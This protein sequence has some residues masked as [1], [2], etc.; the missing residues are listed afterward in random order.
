MGCSTICF[1]KILRTLWMGAW[2]GG[3]CR[4]GWPRRRCEY[5]GGTTRPPLS[6]R[7]LMKPEKHTLEGNMMI[8]L[9]LLLALCRRSLRIRAT[10]ISD[11]L[12]F[13]TPIN[14][15]HLINLFSSLYSIL[16]KSRE[17]VLCMT[18][19]HAWTRFW[20]TVSVIM[21]LRFQKLNDYINCS[22]FYFKDFRFCISC[23][24][25]CGNIYI[26]E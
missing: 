17:I 5:P 4:G 24:M 12:S 18:K 20:T 23:V 11:S 8:L 15:V 26:I 14:I 22:L 9:L 21:I 13:R 7:V 19:I 6:R 2:I 1:R 16:K 3:V 10:T 25:N